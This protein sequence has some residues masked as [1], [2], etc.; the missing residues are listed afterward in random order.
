MSFFVRKVTV[1]SIRSFL[2]AES[3]TA[4]LGRIRLYFVS[5]G[6]G[7]KKYRSKFLFRVSRTHR[8]CLRLT[9]LKFS[10]VNRIWVESKSFRPWVK[11]TRKVSNASKTLFAAF[12]DSCNLLSFSFLGFG[13]LL[14]LDPLDPELPFEL[15]L[16]DLVSGI[17]E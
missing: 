1:S 16:L 2:P 10:S 7:Q 12:T 13:V 15:L 14:L 17:S 6:Q 5:N 3:M 8:Y 9:S 4:V 11:V